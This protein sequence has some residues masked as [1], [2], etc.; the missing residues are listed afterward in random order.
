MKQFFAMTPH[1]LLHGTSAQRIVERSS[2]PEFAWL[3]QEYRL[4]DAQYAQ[5]LEL[6]NAYAPKCEEMCRLIDGKNAQLQKL[7]AATNVV[8]PEINQALVEAAEIRAECESAML[9]HFYKVAQTMPPEQGRRYLD[10]A[11]QRTLKPGHRPKPEV[12]HLALHDATNLVRNRY[13]YRTRH[14]QVSLDAETEATGGSLGES[15]PENKPTPSKSLQGAERAAAV[16][17]AVAQLPEELRTP[18]I[19]C[20]YEEHSHAEI[21]A[22][23]NCTAKA[24]ETRIYRARKQLRTSRHWLLEK[25]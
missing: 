1:Q 25:V 5:V 14:P 24:V 11:Q 16:R 3:Q 22:I 8:T 19:L 7:L 18:L 23:L 10:W 4:S 9:D 2:R 12:F 6:H 15:V 13:R 21:G 20:E 17:E